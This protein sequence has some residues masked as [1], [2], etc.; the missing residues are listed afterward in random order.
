MM[1]RY[2]KDMT[3][4]RHRHGFYT[5]KVKYHIRYDTTR[6]VAHFEYIIG[7]GLKC[8]SL[9]SELTCIAD[10]SLLSAM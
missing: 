6:N 2:G 4:T 9:G 5:Q 8:M 1:Q 7:L 3:R 10:D